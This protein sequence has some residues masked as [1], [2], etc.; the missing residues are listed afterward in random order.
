MTNPEV[1]KIKLEVK[2]IEEY[3]AGVGQRYVTSLSRSIQ[4]Q[5]IIAY[6]KN[7][8]SRLVTLAHAIAEKIEKSA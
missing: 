6:I 4:P 1:D 5:E 2:H 3:L 7:L 8:E